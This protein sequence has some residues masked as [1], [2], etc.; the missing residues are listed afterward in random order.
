[1]PSIGYGAS[2]AKWFAIQNS[3]QASYSAPCG[4]CVAGLAA[5]AED[6]RRRRCSRYRRC[7]CALYFA[8]SKLSSSH[9]SSSV[10]SQSSPVTVH[11]P[12]VTFEDLA[13]VADDRRRLAL[14]VI[15]RYRV[16]VMSTSMHFSSPVKNDATG[17][18][19]GPPGEP[20][21]SK[22]AP[23][24]PKFGG[25]VALPFVHT[26]SVGSMRRPCDS[27]PV[28][29]LLL[30]QPDVEIDLGPQR[31]IRRSRRKIRQGQR[32]PFT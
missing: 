23:L 2:S 14:E 28:R 32:A 27:D 7:R 5:Q 30:R 16:T 26:A 18:T 9:G 20:D 8:T 6:V 17:G 13:D 3:G 31:R 25:V 11:R 12:V 22:P 10:M 15:A 29:R 1:M 4:H 19:P 24:Q 21:G